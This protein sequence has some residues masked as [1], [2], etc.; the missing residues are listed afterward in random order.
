[1]IVFLEV[2]QDELSLP[3]QIADSVPDLAAILEIPRGRIY[4]SMSRYKKRM[5][6]GKKILR[7]KQYPQ[8]VKVKIPEGELITDEMWEHY[9]KWKRGQK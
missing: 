4:C 9:Q 1:M 2:S 6:E 3:T 7:N 5:A 8:F